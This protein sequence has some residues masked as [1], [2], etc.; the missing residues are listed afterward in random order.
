[1][2]AGALQYPRLAFF[3]LG[4]SIAARMLLALVVGAFAVRE[5]I[6]MRTVLLYPLRDLLGF[7]YWA[8][9]YRS[10]L[11]LWRGREFRLHKDGLMVDAA[12]GYQEDETALSA[13]I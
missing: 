2:A 7:L 9:S 1:V 10:D 8:A 4:Y 6:L 5:R 12:A 13:G 3:L 11:I